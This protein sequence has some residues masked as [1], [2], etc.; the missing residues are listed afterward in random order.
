MNQKNLN[1]SLKPL[2]DLAFLFNQSNNAIPENCSGSENV[3]QSKYYDTDKLQQL[4]R[5]LYLYFT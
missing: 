5:S 3:I 4:R 2:P 1:S